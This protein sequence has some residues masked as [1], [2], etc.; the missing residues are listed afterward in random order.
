MPRPLLR[1]AAMQRLLVLVAILWPLVSSAQWVGGFSFNFAGD[2]AVWDLSGIHSISN[3]T[4]EIE[5]SLAHAPNGRV[6][7]THALQLR[8]S[9]ATIRANETM[10]G[11]VGVARGQVTLAASGTGRFT[12]MVSGFPV[13]GTTSSSTAFA[14]DPTSRTVGGRQ[15]ATFCVPARGCQTFRTNVSFALPEGVDGSWSLTL[16]ITNDAPVRGVATVQLANGRTLDWNVRGRVK[17]EMARLRLVGIDETRGIGLQ[18]KLGSDGSL[19]SL[20]GK[21]FGQPVR[22]AAAADP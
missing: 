7:G 8:E 17:G 11:R 4:L 15:S 3:S 13:S 16:S 6:T 20:R 9:G 5:Q 18:A 14:L 19:R 10:R 22:F 2:Q 21:L 1:F 12:G